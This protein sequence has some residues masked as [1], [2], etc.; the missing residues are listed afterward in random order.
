VTAAILV[1][2]GEWAAAQGLS[3]AL[4]DLG[5]HAAGVVRSGAAALELVGA[6]RP[7]LALVDVRLEGPMDGIALGAELR[8]RHRVPVVYLAAHADRD[9]VE[10]LKP[11]RPHGFVSRPIDEGQLRAAVE[12]ALQDAALERR[13]LE[14]RAGDR[15]RIH[16]LEARTALLEGRLREV[17]GLV[18]DREGDD[19]GAASADAAARVRGL[20]RREIEI[21]RMLI[22][23][24]RV[25]SISRDLSIS[26]HTVR[27]HV[28]AIL[29]KFGVHSQDELLD[30]VRG[31]PPSAFQDPRWDR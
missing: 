25:A 1:V 26:V 20:S 11:T 2:A 8:E 6:E 22:E 7:D 24:R 12:L 30:A 3:Q 14:E 27:N 4:A 16:E 5:Y 15:A 18:G 10:R 21:V 23:G 17:A 29:R 28:R 13:R 19:G 9:T 31:L